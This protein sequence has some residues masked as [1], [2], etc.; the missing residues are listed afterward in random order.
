MI[1][2]IRLQRVLRSGLEG[3]KALSKFCGVR[4]YSTIWR[5]FLAQPQVDLRDGP[6]APLTSS[7]ESNLVGARVSAQACADPSQQGPSAR[8]KSH[9]LLVGVH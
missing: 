3:R 1:S 6:R 8:L 2:S 4:R 5:L 7:K 9:G